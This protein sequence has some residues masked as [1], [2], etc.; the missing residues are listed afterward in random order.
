MNHKKT[1][2]WT[3]NPQLQAD[4]YSYASRKIQ[5]HLNSQGIEVRSPES[6][7]SELQYVEKSVN[8]TMNDG[9]F[10]T[11]LFQDRA[12][13]VVNNCLP[14]SYTFSGDYNV[15]FTYWETDKIPSMWIDSIQRCDEIWTT[16]KWA[17]DVFEQTAG[18]SNV[19]NFNLGIDSDAFPVN[20]SDIYGGTFVFLHVGGPSRR[21]NSQMAV[22]AF[23]RL[24][25][26]NPGFHLILKTVGP[27]DA[28]IM[29][30][31]EVFSNAGNNPQISVIDWKMSDKEL[32]KLMSTVHCMVYPTM[33]EGWGMIPFQSIAVGTPTICTNATACTEFAHLSV[34]LDYK[35]SSDNTFGIYKEGRWAQPDFDD[36]CDKMLYIYN[37]YHSVKQKTLEGADFIHN[38]YS[39]ES[40]SKEYGDRLCQILNQ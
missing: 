11:Q 14:S 12:N 30:N 34:P 35:W 17:K 24:F 2:C 40:V 37:N 7:V 29:K 19:K 16:S 39:W 9:F 38:N 8:V 18:A 31:G 20:R 32:G 26:G 36:L 1:I 13:V 6:F 15:G 21:K 4:G 10:T 33:G 23:L 22:D 3:G 28:R 5:E 27:S 25:G